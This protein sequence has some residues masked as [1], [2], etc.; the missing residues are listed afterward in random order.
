MNT[1]AKVCRGL[2]RVA[3]LAVLCATAPASLRAQDFEPAEPSTWAIK[4]GIFLPSNGT[5][6][7]QTNDI[8]TQ[9]GLMYTPNFRTRLLNGDVQFGA[10]FAWE[11]SS[12]A[13]PLYARIVW[14]LSDESFRYQVY[15]GVGGAVYFINSP[16]ISSTVQA[17]AQFVL[18]I[19]LSRN[20]FAELQYDW[21]SGYSDN[22]SNSVRVDGLKL[23]LGWRK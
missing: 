18:G 19:H 13:I 3:A 8:W 20:W 21:V 14:P 6:K 23:Q 15:G 22:L 5:L 16:N 12:F 17:G 1:A 11:S 10:D 9:V 7:Q 2:W 4:A